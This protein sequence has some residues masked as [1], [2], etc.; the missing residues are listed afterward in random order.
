MAKIVL[1]SARDIALDKLVAS[2]VNVRRIKAGVSVEDLAEDIARRGL[3]QSLN[4]RPELDGEGAETGRFTVTAGGRRLA[5]LKLLV[6]Q[7]RLAKNAPVP[8]IVK[9]DGIEEEDSLAEN[10][11]REALH[12]L[13]QFRAFERLLGQGLAIEEIAARFFVSAQVVR[14][15]LKLAAASPKLLDLYVAEE[16]SLEQLMAFTV[17]EDHARQ[18]QVWESLSRAFNK[19]PHTIRRMLTEGA[20]KT[21]DRRAVF[22]GV[23]AYESAGGTVLRDL[24][25]SDTG[26]WLQNTALLDRLAREKLA[27][28]ADRI[29]AEGWKWC[30]FSIDFPYGHTAGLRRLPATQAPLTE[31]EQARH[32]AVL[33]EYG[34]LSDEYEGVEELPE[35]VDRRLGELEQS[36]AAVDERLP[37]Y[38][39]ADMARAGVFVS[40]DYQGALKIE[41]GY[42]RPEDEARAVAVEGEASTGGFAP[43]RSG[44]GGEYRRRKRGASSGHAPRRRADG[45]GNGCAG[46]G[47]HHSSAL[48]SAGDRTHRRSHFGATR[49]VGQRAECRL[50][51]CVA[52][53]LPWRLLPPS[54]KLLPGDHGEEFG[55]QHTGAG[56]RRDRFG[57]SHRRPP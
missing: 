30:E 41:G 13:D 43:R 28:E 11:M 15:R 10:T 27:K 47:R 5:A 56:A 55:V 21:S 26:G 39:P 48:G 54:L 7:K 25:S 3:L 40:L 18:E 19:D 57:Q 49:C 16:M 20:V 37:V 24:F 46:G 22:V 6:K 50:P 52:C 38:D 51:G 17:T 44:T 4:V 29:G 53:A 9:A 35:E 1:T 8:C 31:D 34:A 42:I 12:P 45:F 33:A 2:D 14:Q 23:E 32:D 36:I